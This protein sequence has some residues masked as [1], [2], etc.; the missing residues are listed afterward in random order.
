[1][2]G[3]KYLGE[4]IISD[5]GLIEGDLRMKVVLTVEQANEVLKYLSQKP[6]LEVVDLIRMISQCVEKPTEEKPK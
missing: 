2:H 4:D 1:M 5:L 6:Y 3:N